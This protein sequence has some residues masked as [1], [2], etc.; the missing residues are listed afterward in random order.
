[1]RA[2]STIFFMLL[3]ISTCVAQDDPFSIRGTCLQ[4]PGMCD[5]DEPDGGGNGPRRSDESPARF[6]VCNKSGTDYDVTVVTGGAYWGW[7]GRGWYAVNRN[8]CV[9]LAEG[10]DATQSAY[11]AVRDFR[12][13]KFVSYQSNG[14][15]GS[16]KLPLCVNGQPV[17]IQYT[18]GIMGKL[19]GT[20]ANPPNCGAVEFFG[21]YL[22]DGGTTLTLN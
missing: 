13:K 16:V 3:G 22:G 2:S 15:V 4:N 19:F 7:H 20:R 8:V 9:L 5:Q 10:I 17:D 1:M 21:V 11:L 14:A 12:A 6:I 18:P